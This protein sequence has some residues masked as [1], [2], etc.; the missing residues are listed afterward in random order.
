MLRIMS[1][2]CVVLISSCS[3]QP[4]FEEMIQKYA[5]NM[6][7]FNNIANYACNLQTDVSWWNYDNETQLDG[8]VDFQLEA[9][10]EELNAESIAYKKKPN[11]DCQ[12]TIGMYRRSFG[13]SGQSYSYSYNKENPYRYDENVHTYEK[14][15]DSKY[16]TNIDIILS[17]LNTEK[18][19]YFTFTYS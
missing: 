17:D 19:W 10:L 16:D 13:G 12:L 8:R 6:D 4:T 18:K 14:I 9:W 5:N 7:V 2:G 15:I 1:V 11:G 3:K